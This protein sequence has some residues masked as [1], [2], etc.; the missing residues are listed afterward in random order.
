MTGTAPAR[1]RLPLNTL[2]I[3]FGLSG[4]AGTWTAAAAPLGAPAVV[5]DA[6]WF[7][8][9]GVW[10]ATLVR[11]AAGV[12]RPRDLIDDLR[13]PVLG[14]F[15]AL[16]PAAGSLLAARLAEPFP[17]VGAGLVW[18]MLA[19]SAAFGA[20]FVAG[21]LS[22]PR[23]AATLHGGHLLPTVAASLIS[24]QSLAAVGHRGAAGVLFAAGLVFWLLIGS[25]LLTRFTTG[26][27]VPGPLLPTLAIFSAPPAVAGNAWW[28]MAG[29]QQSIPHE[30]LLGAMAALLLPHLFLIRRYTRIPFVTG[31]WALTFTTAASATYGIRLLSLTPSTAHTVIGWAVLVTATAVVGAVAVRSL[32][33]LPLPRHPF[34]GHRLQ[35][36]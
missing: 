10:A 11:Y 4:L 13:H 31:F 28:T 9:A 17:A 25:L 23:D 5:G 8:A 33:L 3:G 14:P 6:L 7:T 2:G 30:V 24:A 1:T 26:P 18:V 12:R 36:G 19:L 32:A 29:P 34:A 22:V 35:H 20:W 21:L 27:D 15:A 16:A